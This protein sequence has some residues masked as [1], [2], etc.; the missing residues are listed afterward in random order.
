[1]EKTLQ[2]AKS[3][4]SQTRRPW[5]EAADP[6]CALVLTL[7]KIG[8]GVPAA[9]K[10]ITDQGFEINLFWLAPKA[11]A[12]LAAT[13]I[14]RLS[15][16]SALAAIGRGLDGHWEM[17]V[18][19]AA[20][21]SLTEGAARDWPTHQR[22]AFVSLQFNTSWTQER[23]LNHGYVD[24]PVCTLCKAGYGILYHR[25]YVCQ[26]WA[27]MKEVSASPGLRQAASKARAA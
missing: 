26:A 1:M 9:V 19:W 23:L 21:W 18:F 24:S 12:R 3:R 6:A 27:P 17:P 5:R 20:T 4:L 15:D 25:R 16:V 14:H 7:S 10:F 22:H 8:W 2:H 11:V 13:A